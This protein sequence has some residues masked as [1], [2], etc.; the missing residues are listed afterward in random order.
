MINIMYIINESQFGGAALSLFDVLEIGKERLNPTVIIPSTGEIQERLEQLHIKYY[1]VSFKLNYGAIGVHTVMEA[2]RAFVSNYNAA[3]K[4]QKIIKKEKIQLIHTN[5]SVSNVGELAATIA[6]I[7]HV[8][9]IREFMEEDF[10][11]EFLDKK[12]QI[13]LLE[14]SDMIITISECVRDNFMRK[15]GIDSVCI[16]NGIGAE[17]FYCEDFTTKCKNSFMMAGTIIPAKGQLDAVRAVNELVK[18]GLDV[19]LYIIGSSV[20]YQYMWILH[21]FIR[22][23]GLESSVYI[24]PFRNDLSELRKNCQYSITGSRMEALGRVTIEA[25]LAG[26]VVIGADSGGTAEIIGHDSERG[27]LYEQG[28]Y[29]DLARVMLYALEHTENNPAIQEKAQSYALEEFDT[30][31][32]LENI[33]NIYKNV[34][35]NRRADLSEKRIKLLEK[36]KTRYLQTEGIMNCE[37]KAEEVMDEKER[38]LQEIKELWLNDREKEISVDR[39]LI[40]KGIQTVAIYGMGYLGCHLYDELEN[41]EIDIKYV[42]DRE[43]E[44]LAGVLRVIKLDGEL[45]EV[46]AVVVTVLGDTNRICNSIRRKCSYKILTLTEVLRWCKEENNGEQD[47]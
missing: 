3:L 38:K 25:M 10:G 4:L 30:V 28:N 15:Y 34:I 29:K 9:H 19:R 40:K 43:L 17:R 21:K 8:W 20:S 13:E 44:D 1:I 46:D 37:E 32:Y 22:Q 42:M 27:Y 31:K 7:P 16:H 18:Q 47:K 11:I 5:S 2:D 33:I 23:C 26:C 45:P 6:G 12:L 14:C 36:I 24:F 35:E 41:S 39:T